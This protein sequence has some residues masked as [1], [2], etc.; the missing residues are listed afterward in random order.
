[1]IPE[2]L[3]KLRT[4]IN[5]QPPFHKPLKEAIST[6]I[7]KLVVNLSYLMGT[8]ILPFSKFSVGISVVGWI[9]SH[10]NQ[11]HDHLASECPT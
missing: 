5:W 4:I 9:V 7:S 2:L 1:M 8:A 11:S 6:F 3:M 10:V